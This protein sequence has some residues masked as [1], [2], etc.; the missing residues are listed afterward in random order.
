MRR[1]V[2]V[3]PCGSE[4][5]LEIYRSVRYSTHF[6]LVGGS[7]VS[8]H[9]RFV[10]ESYVGDIPYHQSPEFESRIIEI[11]KSHHIDVIYPAMDAVAETLKRIEPE[12]GIPVVGSCLRTT[13][14]CASKAEMFT[15]L[16]DIVDFPK[17]H[18]DFS[19]V[20]QEEFPVFIKP[21]RGYGGRNT[22]KANNAIAGQAFLKNREETMLIFEYLPGDEWTVD[23]FTDRHGEL[24]FHATRRRNRISN[25]ISVNTSPTEENAELFYK[26][27]A[28]INSRLNLRGAWFFQAKASSTGNPKFLEIAARLGGSSSLFRARGIN[29]SLL[30]L[31]DLFENDV[32]LTE[33]S[34]SI[35]MDRALGNT[36]K[37]S[38]QYD[39]VFVDLD[40]CLVINDRLNLVLLAFL[41]QAI[42]EKKK[43][44]LITRH[45]KN[46]EETLSY[47]RLQCLFDRVIHIKDE[48]RAKSSYI[49]CEAS[50]FID[51]SHREREDVKNM[52]GIPV[53]SP[54][55]I[56][57]LLKS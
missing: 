19:G 5:G 56:E 46:V 32:V 47:Y 41:Y 35:E 7:S 23:C 38:I 25:G 37:T 9:G 8:D 36:Y 44:S 55:M 57:I 43:I 4:I 1:R 22:F 27:A 3:F 17:F 52:L 34:Y 28:A 53:F 11:I 24:R 49:D 54:D 50:I 14:I 20:C 40:D 10:Y 33:N 42:G 2:L 18:E 45:H 12:L 48:K 26:W 29:F 13:E 30:S 15:A 39:E 21:D 16:H 6:E 51:D 31:F